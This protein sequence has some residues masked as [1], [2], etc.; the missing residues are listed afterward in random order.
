[1]NPFLAAK[2]GVY[3]HGLS[4]DVAAKQ[5]SPYGVMASDLLDGLTEVL[6][7]TKCF[8]KEGNENETV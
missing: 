3:L 4:G 8:Q 7:N 6:I 1:M 5:K 2:L